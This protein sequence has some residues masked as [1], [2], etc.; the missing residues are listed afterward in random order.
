[1]R[2]KEEGGVTAVA[3]SGP[4]SVPAHCLGPAVQRSGQPGRVS[5]LNVRVIAL[6]YL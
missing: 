3:V 6:S 2:W 4:A 1:M 5:V